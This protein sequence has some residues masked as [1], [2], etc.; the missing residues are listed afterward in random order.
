MRPTYTLTENASLA[1]RNGFRVPARAE[2]FIDVRRNEGLNE[3]L[4]LPWLR[5]APL[6]MLG[7]GSNTLFVGDV[8]GAVISAGALGRQVLHS[9]DEGALLH[10]AAGE[11]WNDVVQ[12]SLGLGL[13]GLENLALIPGT[14]GAAP[15]QNIGA[16]GT[17]VGEFITRIE[18]WDR[19]TG[20]GVQLSR[21]ACAFGYRNSLFKREPQRYLILA[22]ELY[23][24]RQQPPRIDYPGLAEE[25]AAIGAATP[26]RPSQIAEAITRLRTRKLPDPM[27]LP[28]VGSFFRNP[29]LPA[30]QALA[31]QAEHPGLPLFPAGADTGLRKLPAAWLIEHC[32]WKGHREG[33]AGIA[34]Q[35]ALVLVNHGQASGAQLLDLARRVAASVQARFGVALEPEARIIGATW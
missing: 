9:D 5:Q 11:R 20:H 31:L 24:P 8:P 33:D 35:H 34:A 25:L 6:L 17:E 30:A 32:G 16:Y 26:P 13:A 15:V 29:V 18:A 4:A 19:H 10:V 3:L 27:Q 14:A 1:A 12:W 23:L 2:L 21:D 7:E 22:L 28:N